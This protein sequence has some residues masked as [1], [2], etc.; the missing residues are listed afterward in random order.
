MSSDLSKVEVA[1]QR[2]S[3]DFFWDGFDFVDSGVDPIYFL[4]SGTTGW[5]YAFDP[6]N[7]ADEGLYA[8]FSKA[9]D[10][11]GNFQVTADLF[12]VVFEIDRTSPTV[13][14]VTS[15]DANG[16]YTHASVISIQIAFD[17]PVFV[18]GTPELD[19]NSGGTAFFTAGRGPAR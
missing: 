9:T 11:A 5:S 18:T 17:E 19:L 3:D 15:P 16:V 4:A 14:D 1:F 12:E 10:N 13:T 7:F 6:A 2:D 8:A